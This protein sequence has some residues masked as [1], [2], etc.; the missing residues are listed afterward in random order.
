MNI[1][2]K[3]AEVVY[4]RKDQLN[5]A[6]A[7]PF[8]CEVGPNERADKEPIYTAEQLQQAQREAVAAYKADLFQKYESSTERATEAEGD[9]F[10]HGYLCGEREAIVPE[11]IKAAIKHAAAV[12]ESEA[13][14]LTREATAKGI[15]DTLREVLAAAPEVNP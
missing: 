8:L 7:S 14:P 10:T 15:R 12:L 5:K 4:I 6:R 1:N 3:L 9:A 13:G 2:K 11:S